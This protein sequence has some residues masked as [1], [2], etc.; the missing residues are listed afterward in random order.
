THFW[1][2]IE[3]EGVHAPRRWGWP[4]AGALVVACVVALWF[5]LGRH[6]HG[7]AEPVFKLDRA[8]V[9]MRSESTTQAVVDDHLRVT[10]GETSEVWIYRGEHLVLRCRARERSA[11][12]TPEPDG[13]IVE[14]VLAIPG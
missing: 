11:A 12:C 14:L 8:D 4:L 7:R 9:A 6:R 1:R 10:V 5:G 3:A 13:M 2:R